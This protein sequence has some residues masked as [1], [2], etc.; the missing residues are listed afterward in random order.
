MSV[1]ARSSQARTDIDLIGCAEQ[2]DVVPNSQPLGAQI[3]GLDLARPLSAESIKG[4]RDAWSEHLV[5]LI[6]G[7]HLSIGQHLAFA[8]QLGEILQG[9]E[10]S[11]TA[12]SRQH[13][14]ILEVSTLDANGQQ[15]ER[16]LG[17]AESFWHTDMSYKAVP[18]AASFLFSRE[19]PDSGGNTCFANMYR[20]FETLSPQLADAIEGKRAVHDESRNSAGRLRPGYTDERD[21]RHTP[22]PQHPLVRT[23][24]VT[25]RKALYLGRRPYS[26][27]TGL[28]LDDSE[29]LLDELWEHAATADF[30]WCHEWAVGDMIIWDNRCTMHR[31]DEF[32]PAV[33]RVMHR[34]QI[35]GTVP[36]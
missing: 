14:G 12:L 17:S 29:A 36:S 22:G 15:R 2:L 35:V 7:Q 3:R 23:H 24:P 30:E 21:P 34:T 28:S 26:Y 18:P 27:V 8:A 6:R 9:N 31:R 10:T 33:H 32:D 20:A 11:R 13:K 19:V 5:L 4:I 1:P 16:G 25:G